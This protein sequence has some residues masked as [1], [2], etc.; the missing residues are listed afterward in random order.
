MA[1]L[2][3]LNVQERTELG[4]GPNRR[5]RATGMVPGIY[6]DAK[7]ANIAVK[8]EMIPLQKAYHQLGNA[9]VFDLVLEKDGKTETMPALLWRVRNEPISGA[10]EHVDFFGVDLDKDIKIAVHF[11]LTGTSPGVKL[12][13]VLEQ[14][15]DVVDVIC[16]PMSIPESITIDISEMEILDSIRIEDVTF[17]EGVTPV[18]DENYAVVTIAAKREEEEEDEEATE[19]EVIGASESEEAS[20]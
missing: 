14:Y 9:Q 15:R 13:G 8:A 12:G 16:K 18:F 19:T 4:K 7:G 6:Y 10:P 2:L 20:E 1:E 3:K 5:L 11:E 17:P